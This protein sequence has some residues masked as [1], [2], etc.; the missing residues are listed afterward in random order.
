MTDGT[1][2][3][4]PYMTIH[5]AAKYLRL[6]NP[7]T[8]ETWAG[9][10]KVGNVPAII[11]PEYSGSPFG[12]L[13]EVDDLFHTMPER[14]HMSDFVCHPT[15]VGECTVSTRIAA[16]I[17]DEQSEQVCNTRVVPDT[18]NPHGHV[19]RVRIALDTGGFYP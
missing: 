11:R 19:P 1:K 2:V 3:D 17:S 9:K 10:G 14:Q 6:E 5:E 4:T 8:L 13:V 18:E 16:H 15:A 7:K 12:P